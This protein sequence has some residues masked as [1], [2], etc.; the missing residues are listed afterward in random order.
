MHTE[1]GLQAQASITLSTVID[2]AL[3]AKC[4]ILDEFELLCPSPEDRACSPL[5]DY[6]PVY[7]EHLKSWGSFP[8]HPLVVEVLRVWNLP[9]GHIHPLFS[10]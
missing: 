8:P 2:I 6:H 5:A 4:M 7:K 9:L 3:W 10:K 1:D